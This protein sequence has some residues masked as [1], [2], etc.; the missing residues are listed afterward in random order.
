[1][2]KNGKDILISKKYGKNVKITPTKIR[3]IRG[4]PSFTWFP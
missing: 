4:F 1:M 3:E 2:G